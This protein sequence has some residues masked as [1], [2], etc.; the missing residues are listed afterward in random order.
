MEREKQGRQNQKEEEGERKERR[1]KGR[2]GYWH[3]QPFS[4]SAR[5][6]HPSPTPPPQG[7]RLQP[8]HRPVLV[9][10]RPV[11]PSATYSGWPIM[12][13]SQ[14]PSS[15][16]LK[17]FLK[18]TP[19]LPR[20]KLNAWTVT[21]PAVARTSQTSNPTVSSNSKKTKREAGERGT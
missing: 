20:A 1:R 14:S 7:M 11:C 3:S 6:P 5:L 21:S 12:H 8:A 2:R 17:Q 16:C 13:L 9:R 15:N 18:F 4:V 19:D 10:G